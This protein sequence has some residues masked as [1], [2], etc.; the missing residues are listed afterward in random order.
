MDICS[1]D[2]NKACI[3]DGFNDT[4]EAKWLNDNAYKYGFILRYPEGKQGITG[5]K[6]ESW[7]YRYVGK[8]LAKTLYNNGNWITLEEYFGLTSRYQ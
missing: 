1:T 8:E 5:Y 3:E 6:Y 7:H 2:S 4:D